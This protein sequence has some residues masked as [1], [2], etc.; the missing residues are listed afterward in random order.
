MTKLTNQETKDLL[1]SVEDH[2]PR[3]AKWL[4]KKP[5]AVASFEEFS[6]SK[7]VLGAVNSGTEIPKVG[8]VVEGFIEVQGLTPN[9]CS[10]KQLVS[11]PLAL[12]SR[13]EVIGE[14]EFLTH[15]HL[16]GVWMRR[17][18]AYAGLQTIYFTPFKNTKE[19]PFYEIKDRLSKKKKPVVKVAWLNPESFDP[20]GIDALNDI[21]IRR[22]LP[23]TSRWIPEH[24]DIHSISRNP[25]PHA[26]SLFRELIRVIQGEKIAFRSFPFNDAVAMSSWDENLLIGEYSTNYGEYKDCIVLGAFQSADPSKPIILLPHFMMGSLA[27]PTPD[28]LPQ[29]PNNLGKILTNV[30]KI[31]KEF[32]DKNGSLIPGNPATNREVIAIY[33]KS[34][35]VKTI[36]S[37]NGEEGSDYVKMIGKKI[38]IEQ[39]GKI[40]DLQNVGILGSAALIVLPYKG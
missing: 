22:L 5:A 10:D 23:L 13:G 14:V 6:Y 37:S 24:N 11:Y 34:K 31:A 28:S 40:E 18:V 2:S 1:K 17:W 26:V 33:N 7:E 27:L 25:H 4:R 35:K 8:I 36:R 20:E 9:L 19:G 39:M 38:N 29:F 30:V 3:L 32:I 15:R 16:G 12:R 21:S